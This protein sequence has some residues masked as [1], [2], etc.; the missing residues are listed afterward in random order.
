M[1]SRTMNELF[2]LFNDFGFEEPTTAQP[3]S[4]IV[5]DKDKGVW[6]IE[7]E[8]PGYSKEDVEIKVVEDNLLVSTKE[9]EGARTFNARYYLGNDIDVNSISATMAD[10][11]LVITVR[12]KSPEEKIVKIM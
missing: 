11:L 6:T 5:Y 8:L 10:G 3:F 12:A 4:Q 7:V 2:R 1:L 9:R